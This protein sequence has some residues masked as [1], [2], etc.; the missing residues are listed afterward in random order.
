MRGY[1]IRRRHPHD[2]RAFLIHPADSG[3]TAKVA[4]VQILDETATPFPGTLDPRRTHTACHPAQAAHGNWRPAPG[5][6]TP[7]CPGE[8]SGRN[9]AHE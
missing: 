5:T 7:T 8:M 6:V 2:R 3:R 1:L 9:A 4:A